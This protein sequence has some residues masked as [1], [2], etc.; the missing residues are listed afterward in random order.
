M[1]TL[2]FNHSTSPNIANLSTDYGVRY[3]LLSSL[4]D[5]R[6]LTYSFNV[7]TLVINICSFL[8][9]LYSLSTLMIIT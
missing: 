6:S 9:W 1:E 8:N 2:I 4:K 7:N 5:F 3:L